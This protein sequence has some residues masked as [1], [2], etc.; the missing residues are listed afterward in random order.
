[1][2]HFLTRARRPRVTRR[3]WTPIVALPLA[4]CALLATAPTA[5]SSDYFWRHWRNS[6]NLLCI[7]V[8][9]NQIYSGQRVTQWECNRTQAQ[10]WKM[11][12]KYTSAR[13]NHYY[14]IQPAGHTDYCIDVEGAGTH[15]GAKLL[16]WGCH[17]GHNQLW[18]PQYTGDGPRGPR[19]R[20]V[21]LHSQKCIDVPGATTE[22]GRQLQQYDCNWTNAQNWEGH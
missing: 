7:D 12:H 13:G 17:M 6:G 2:I 10:Y 8:P 21:A 19:Y 1:M 16:L 4:F 20:W 5:A 22:W 11:V 18:H 15:N 3:A 14:Q 9:G